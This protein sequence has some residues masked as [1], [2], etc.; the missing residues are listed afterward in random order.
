LAQAMQVPLEVL[1]EVC[2]C[3]AVLG[4]LV[5]A[6][7]LLEVSVHQEPV[8]QFDFNLVNRCKVVLEVQCLLDLAGLL[9]VT[10]ATPCCLVGRVLAAKVD[11]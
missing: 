9:S 4:L 5:A 8:V 1:A 3:L 2:H 10:L 7:R 6:L 11:L